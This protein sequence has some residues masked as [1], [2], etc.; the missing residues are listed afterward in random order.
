V[1]EILDSTAIL[2][3]MWITMPVRASCGTRQR[4]LPPEEVKDHIIRR[5]GS[6]TTGRGR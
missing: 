6:E 3:Q 4:A 2:D 1:S 5:Y